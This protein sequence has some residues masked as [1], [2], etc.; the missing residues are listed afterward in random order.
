MFN[1]HRGFVSILCLDRLPPCA[2]CLPCVKSG[3]AW[4]QEAIPGDQD[5]VQHRLLQ[6]EVPHPLRDD[7]VYLLAVMQ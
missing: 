1:C 2:P 4:L 3:P 6:K 7:H 5:R